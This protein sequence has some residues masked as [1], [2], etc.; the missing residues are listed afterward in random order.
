MSDDTSPKPPRPGAH[1]PPPSA[2]LP[3]SPCSLVLPTRSPPLC[4]PKPRWGTSSPTC[5]PAWPTHKRSLIAAMIL[6]VVVTPATSPAWAPRSPCARRRRHLPPTPHFLTPPRAAGHSGTHTG[7]VAPVTEDVRVAQPYRQFSVL[8]LTSQEHET[9]SLSLCPGTRAC[10]SVWASSRTPAGAVPGV[11]IA[12]CP[13]AV[14]ELQAP[15]RTSWGGSGPLYPRASL[16]FFFFLRPFCR[17]TFLIHSKIGVKVQISQGAPAPD[18][19]SPSAI[20]PSPWVTPR[21]WSKRTTTWLRH[22]TAVRDSLT[23][24]KVLPTSSRGPPRDLRPLLCPHGPARSPRRVARTGSV[25]GGV[26]HL[27]TRARFPAGFP[28]LGG[29]QFVLTGVPSPRAPPKGRRA[30]STV[31]SCS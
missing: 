4:P 11:S 8:L 12:L 13:L 28:G 9:L 14:P 18:T 6:S 24:F 26:V 22:Y 7:A 3:G 10:L 27:I 19:R 15:S 31:G 5:P 2:W 16:F 21:L 1:C 30:A 25:R 17:A 20:S 23:A 29:F